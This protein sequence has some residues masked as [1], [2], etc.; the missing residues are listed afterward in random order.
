MMKG[1]LSLLSAAVTMALAAS[2]T[3]SKD[4]NASSLNTLKASHPG[5]GASKSKVFQVRNKQRGTR[6]SMAKKSAAQHALMGHVQNHRTGSAHGPR[7][8]SVLYDQTASFSGYG[9][10]SNHFSASSE[11]AS[12]SSINAEGA[13]DFVVGAGGWTVTGFNFLTF[14][15][16]GGAPEDNSEPV[17]V[18][19]Y[20]D[21]GGVPGDTPVCS[22][23]LST[24]AAT[25][26]DTYTALANVTLN[27]P[28]VLPQGTYWVGA[29]FDNVNDSGAWPYGFGLVTSQDN[30]SG[31]WR[32]PLDG[33]GS[34][35]TDWGALADCGVPSSIGY[36]FGFQV[37]GTGGGNPPGGLSLTLTLAID[38]GDPNQCGTSTNLSVSA[39][40]QVNFCYTVT[41]GTGVDLGYQSLADTLGG[42]IFNLQ[43]EDLPDGG[44]IQYNRI[45]TASAATDG[46]VTATWTS[47]EGAPGY[48]SDNTGS[49]NFVDISTTGTSL[50]LGDDDTVGVTVPFS[51][52]F[53]GVATNELCI[54]NNGGIQPGLTSCSLTW[55]NEAN[56]PLP[57]SLFTTAMLPLWDDFG[58]PPTGSGVFTQTNGNAGSRTFIIEW[59][60][61]VH[62]GSG[63]SGNP[64][65]DGATFE[66]IIDE[67]TGNFS[68]EYD[69]V[70]YTAFSNAGTDP[71]DCTD[72]VCGTIGLQQDATFANQY[73]FDT[74][75]IADGMSIAWTPSDIGQVFTATAS[76]TLDVGAPAIAVDPASFDVT[77]GQNA[78]STDTLTIDNTGDRDLDWTISEAPG[79]SGN[80]RAH[81]PAMAYPTVRPTAEQIRHARQTAVMHAPVLRGR[82]G[83]PLFQ[84]IR[85][86]PNGGAQVPSF[87]NDTSTASY[88][89]LDAL[90]PGTLNTVGPLPTAP[91]QL[92]GS[93]ANNDFS[94]EYLIGYS[95]GVNSFSTIDT[96]TGAVTVINPSVSTDNGDIIL[97]LRWDAST[98]TM[99]ASGVDGAGT[100]SHIFTVDIAAG[101]FTTV[102]EVSGVLLESIAFDSSGNMYGL[103]L[104][105]DN[106]IA[107]DKSTGS[108]QVVLP[109]GFDAN[110]VQD[111][112]IDPT[113]DTLYYPSYTKYG[114]EMYS[115]DLA[116]PTAFVDL[117]VIGQNGDELDAFSIA[118]AA[119]GCASPEDVPWLSVSPTSGTTPPGGS[120]DA[121]VTFDSTGLDN[122]TYNAN[123]CVS[124]ND[125]A[126]R[127]V[128]VPVTLTV[129][130]GPDDTIFKDGFDGSG[131]N[132]TPQ[133]F[134]WDD[135]SYENAIGLNNQV[136]ESAAIWLNRFPLAAGQFPLTLSDIDIEW[137]S[138]SSAGGDLTGLDVDI[139]VYYDADGDGDP[140]NATL[141]AQS[142]ATIT[143]LDT[144]VT[145]PISASIPGSG[146]IYVGFESSYAIGGASPG[147]LFPAALDQDSGSHHDSWVSAGSSGDPDV[148]NLGNNGL[149]G[150]I[151]DL[152]SSL[153]GN[154]LIRANGTSTSGAPVQFK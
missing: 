85:A 30:A 40:D 77:L 132:P 137:P 60:D 70:S 154:W 151:D 17:D 136:T 153:A 90:V 139:L 111:F 6:A 92:G 86:R 88:V 61:L 31:V 81:F 1:R 53:Y 118:V 93:F 140:S 97:A 50:G 13:D 3:D 55:N 64:N 114:G 110:Y 75:S 23:P 44:S 89:S 57:S 8:S 104:G 34:G 25:A 35:C 19:V 18:Y 78:T 58:P 113:T 129:N 66:V 12:L 28:C 74:A 51:F 65:T 79:D 69:D 10:Y 73:S 26:F 119:G 131:G 100:T 135:G 41:N 84:P 16:Y 98:S 52:N 76:A 144:F 123:I 7:G 42:A 68:F 87:A 112:D 59:S 4:A 107:I 9:L 5:S 22:S 2:A 80:T 105:G 126:N 36:G 63:S 117:G 149:T 145:Y 120:S 130:G 146:D 103:D 82:D 15:F 94:K 142:P 115:L 72:G 122:G 11:Y 45:V 24:N 83:K 138:G 152:A 141:V 56:S 109:F 39:G 37:V 99:Y 46:T 91:L 125:A 116:N 106:L 143:A 134:Q 38:N 43:Q 124:S 147:L 150:V 21:D 48:N 148:E 29:S 127:T 20:P 95:G 71:D 121:T 54:G 101:T 67:A 14:N 32:N 62:Y 133:S 49:S 128:A 47:Q 108:S 33:Y 27:A 96:T 102:G